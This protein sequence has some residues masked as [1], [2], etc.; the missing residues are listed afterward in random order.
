MRVTEIGVVVGMAMQDDASSR[1]SMPRGSRGCM[2]GV[3]VRGWLFRRRRSKGNQDPEAGRPGMRELLQRIYEV[4]PVARS[5][6]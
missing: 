6:C 1:A 3:S 2:K 5:R 4:A